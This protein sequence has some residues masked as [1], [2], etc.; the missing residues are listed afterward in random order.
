M[1]NGQIRDLCLALLHADTEAEVIEVLKKAG[2]WDKP[3][4]WRY[5]TGCLQRQAA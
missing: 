2:Y 3:A 4:A 1:T 5:L